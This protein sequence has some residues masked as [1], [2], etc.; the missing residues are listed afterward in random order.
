MRQ[1]ER[2]STL[3]CLALF[4]RLF[5]LEVSGYQPRNINST[6]FPNKLSVRRPHIIA[7]H[8][9]LCQKL[10]RSETK[11]HK[12]RQR[13]AQRQTQRLAQRRA[14][15]QD[16]ENQV[17]AMHY[18]HIRTR[19]DARTSHQVKVSPQGCGGSLESSS[20]RQAALLKG[21][22]VGDGFQ[23]T[24]GRWIPGGLH[25]SAGFAALQPHRESCRERA[26]RFVTTT[27]FRLSLAPSC[28]RP[29]H[30]SPLSHAASLQCGRAAPWNRRIA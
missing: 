25:P 21:M 29:L 28:P 2:E 13:R 24:M 17:L 4:L 27:R 22:G 23:E 7:W 3:V 9:L 16:S 20:P 26:R 10:A 18:L 15:R 14:Q 5:Q 6:S 1:R 8:R 12:D 19:E 11:T 30:P